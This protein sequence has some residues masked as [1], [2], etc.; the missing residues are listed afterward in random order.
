[1]NLNGH[2][3]VLFVFSCLISFY[4]CLVYFAGLHAFPSKI[5]NIKEINKHKN[6]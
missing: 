5:V 1:M 4:I 6:T 3:Y 2:L